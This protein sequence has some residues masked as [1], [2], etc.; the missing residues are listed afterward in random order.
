MPIMSDQGVAADTVVDAPVRPSFDLEEFT[1][2]PRVQYVVSFV[3]SFV[4]VGLALRPWA[5][6]HHYVFTSGTDWVWQQGT[7]QAHADG[8]P[9]GA[10]DHLAWP[11]GANAWRYPQIGMLVAV[12]A[13]VTVGLLGM[14]TA[15]ATLWCLTFAAGLNAVGIVYMI[16]QFGGTRMGWLT[17]AWAISISSSVFVVTHQI[18]LSLFCALP[19]VLGACAHALRSDGRPSKRL[20]V[21]VV[22]VGFLTPL[23]WIVVLFLA[24]PFLVLPY[25]ARRKWREA[26]HV[27]AV[28]V[29]MSIGFAMQT[30]IFLL[31]KRGGPGDDVSRQAFES[32]LWFGHL[33]D[34]FT[35]SPTLRR[36]LP[37]MFSRLRPGTTL[38]IGYGIPLLA[39]TALVIGLMLVLPP[40]RNREGRD[41]TLLTAMSVTFLLYWLGGGLGNLQAALA[42]AVGGVSPARV[43]Y[44]MVLPLA[45]VGAAWVGTW[46]EGRAAHRTTRRWTAVAAALLLLL[47]VSDLVLNEDGGLTY[48]APD[49][50][51][52]DL[53]AIQYLQAHTEPCPVAQFPNEAIP[54]GVIEAS[55]IISPT[56]YRGLIPY[57]IA[58]DYRW[59]AGSFS[60]A[61]PDALASLPGDITDADLD[62]LRT[63]G[64]CAVLY[65][66]IAG[67]PAVEQQAPLSGRSVTFSQPADFED[68]RYQLYLL[69]Q[70]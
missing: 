16:R 28:W 69:D 49:A 40:R 56:V 44:R 55:S 8:G 51:Q 2:T 7:F 48:T 21:G 58:P 60:R 3:V 9:W 33:A 46:S 5:Y 66:R 45:I 62:A 50:P 22:L 1:S 34:L 15:S 24:V 26:L 42:A 70:G 41:T 63:M 19:F 12:F 53:P 36:A 31:A 18:N 54:N 17:M 30:A 43:W 23:W 61:E 67:A 57:V 11:G 27:A 14:G 39:G 4:L 52:Y 64:F 35:G 20:L 29:A 32:N 10:T 6:A 59:T 25:A 47:T 65:D 37:G 38:D 13:W 68:D